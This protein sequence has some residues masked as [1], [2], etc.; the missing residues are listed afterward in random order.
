MEMRGG[1]RFRTKAERRQIVEE[2]MRPGASVSRVARIRRVEQEIDRRLV[3]FEH[4]VTLWQGIPGID[5]VTACCLVAEI[6]LNMGQFP[7]AQHMA[8]WAGIC[9]GH[10]ESA[11][12]RK[13][14]TI[15]DGNRWLRRA[16]CQAAWAASRK[17]NCYLS[18]QFKRIAARRGVKRALIAVAHAILIIAY[19]MLK[20]AE[21]YRE[22]GG[23]YLEHIHKEQMQKHLIRRLKR[24]GLTVTVQP[25]A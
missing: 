12:K 5:R 8:S 24:L 23:D 25:A 20:T 19:T 2:T 15:R 17:K 11:G 13:S 14:G 18:S 9:P 10:N 1:K 7:S 21:S 22:L 6:G 4:A 16:I 3:P